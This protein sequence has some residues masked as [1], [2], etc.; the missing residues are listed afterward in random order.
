M[1]AADAATVTASTKRPPAVS[2]GKVGAPATHISGLKIVPLLPAL[3]A[4]ADL[5]QE[6]QLKNPREPK[7]TYIFPDP[8]VGNTMLDVVE[9]DLL[10]VSG[11]EYLIH[12]VKEWQRPTEGNYLEVLVTQ[13]KVTVT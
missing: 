3:P 5:V 4:S 12:M 2:G 11:V 10:V 8:E 9:G 1:S 7:V 13:R 6:A